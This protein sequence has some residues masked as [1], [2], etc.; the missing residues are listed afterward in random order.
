M[1]LGRGSQNEGAGQFST[2]FVAVSPRQPP[3][4]TCPGRAHT[5]A[6][7]HVPTLQCAWLS[8]G[9]KAAARPRGGDATREFLALEKALKRCEAVAAAVG[10]RGH[11][12][13]SDLLPF[14]WAAAAAADAAAAAAAAAARPWCP[15][16]LFHLPP[17]DDSPLPPL[18]SSTL[19]LGRPYFAS[20]LGRSLGGDPAAAAAAAPAVAARPVGRRGTL[21]RRSR[22][23][24][25]HSQPRAAAAAA[26]AAAAAA[27]M[28]GAC[29]LARS[30]IRWSY[31]RWP[32]AAGG[33]SGA[34]VACSICGSIRREDPGRQSETR[35][36]AAARSLLCF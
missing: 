16:A 31:F 24:Y 3:V 35:S 19:S 18:L 23:R 14:Q 2:L 34:A 33:S 25:T 4:P 12:F 13:E 6:R 7:A 30:S 9:P 26:V 8:A 28:H 15:R 32:G 20:G 21:W 36:R 17:P 29:S 5:C 1:C 22:A 11:L 27:A 10:R